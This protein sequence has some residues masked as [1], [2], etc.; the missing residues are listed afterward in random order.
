VTASTQLR[1][2]RAREAILK[3]AGERF[4][5]DGLRRTSI[6]AIAAGSGV[7]RPTVYAHFSSKEEIFRT[8]VADLHDAGIE[9]MRA[10][11]DPAAPIA[12]RLYAALAGRFVPFVELTT[13]S[14]HGAE[15]LDETS[16]TCG[17]ITRSS[18]ERSLA[19]LEEL[20][21]SADAVGEISLDE[22][23]VDAGSAA[24]I[25]Y[26]AAHG[27]KEDPSITPQGYQR[28]LRRVVAVLSRGLGAQT[29]RASSDGDTMALP[30]D[31]RQA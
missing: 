1:G 22:A 7:S 10:A 28:Q 26:D 14:V 18:R 31:A 25:Y 5:A 21:S 3:T 2:A 4:L 16:R 20:L 9:A 8:M 23:G 11:I 30:T 17:D 12:D 19:L 24:T 15:L 29:A 13:A 27:T 6:E